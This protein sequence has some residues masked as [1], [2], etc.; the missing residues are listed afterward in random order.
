MDVT[1]GVALVEYEAS[2]M[3]LSGSGDLHSAVDELLTYDWLPVEG[4]DFRVQYDGVTVNGV[5]QESEVFYAIRTS[6]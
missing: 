1:D 4:Q 3:S 6:E 5:G 2:A